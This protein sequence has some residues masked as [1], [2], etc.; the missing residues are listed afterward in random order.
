MVPEAAVCHMSPGR[1]RV[2]V[3]AMRGDDEYFRAVE[4]DLGARFGAVVANSAT[5]SI[6]LTGAGVSLSDVRD[7]AAEHA[8]FALAERR[9]TPADARTAPTVLE[10]PAVPLTTAAVFGL[11]A[12]VQLLR[13]QVLAP[14]TSLFWYA[15]ETLRTSRGNG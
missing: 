15:L 9:P 5:G 6:L 13:G 4:R 12:V 1:I 8:L 3:P 11:L 2:R 10:L 14:A 7:I